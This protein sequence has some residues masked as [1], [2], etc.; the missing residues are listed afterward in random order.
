MV[1]LQA[2]V[3]SNS[4]NGFEILLALAEQQLIG[5]LII[6]TSVTVVWVMLEL[7]PHRGRS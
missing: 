1:G 6:G 7:S 3:T 5:A 2:C 4:I